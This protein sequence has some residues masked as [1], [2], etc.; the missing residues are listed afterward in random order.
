LFVLAPVLPSCSLFFFFSPC[1]FQ[2]EK[3]PSL[4]E[5]ECEMLAKKTFEPGAEFKNPRV[6]NCI[7]TIN[8]KGRARVVLAAWRYAQDFKAAYMSAS[9][10]TASAEAIDFYS[11]I[12]DDN[13]IVEEI[14]VGKTGG[15]G[16]VRVAQHAGHKST[17]MFDHVFAYV[18]SLSFVF[19]A[20]SHVIHHALHCF[21]FFIV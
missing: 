11:L 12:D 21:F 8:L 13:K 18:R 1:V 9:D 6:R 15:Q 4:S 5:R 17:Q 10:K 19:V 14:Y 7:Y 20:L 2:V 16:L 3:V